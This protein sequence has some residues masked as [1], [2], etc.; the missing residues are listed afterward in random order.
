MKYVYNEPHS[1]NSKGERM[2]F[3]LGKQE[4][5]LI[6]GLVVKAIMYMPKTPETMYDLARLRNMQ[7]ELHPLVKKLSNN[8]R[9]YVE[10]PHEDISADAL[11]GDRKIPPLIRKKRTV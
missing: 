9:R 4:A 1:D 8:D 10:N 3:A 7:Q 2:V 5:I 6:Y 11:A